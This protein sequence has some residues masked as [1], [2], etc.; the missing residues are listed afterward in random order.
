MDGERERRDRGVGERERER[1]RS[2]SRIGESMADG[3]GDDNGGRIG[4]WFSL[5]GV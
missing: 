5:G 3:R 1:D 2:S 4:P